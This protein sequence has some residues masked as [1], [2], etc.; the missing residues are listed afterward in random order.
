MLTDSH[1]HLFDY[2]EA[3]GKL[4]PAGKPDTAGEG[5]LAVA[6]ATPALWCLSAHEPAEFAMQENAASA[7]PGRAWLS[8]GIHPQ[9]PEMTHF[10][11]LADLARARRIQ[12]IGECGFDL[13][14]DGFRRTIDRQKTVWS[15]QLDLAIETRLPLIVHCRKA[16][17]LVFADSKRLKCVSAVV[18][19]GWPGSPVEA[20]SFLDKG[21]NAYFSAGKGLMRGDRSLI[22]TVRALPPSRILTETDAPWMRDRDQDYTSPSEI[23]AVAARAAEIAGLPEPDFI[24]TV[25]KNFR[26]VFGACPGS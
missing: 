18:F 15:R 26:T 16:L 21:V 14:N 7:F 20:R 4:P 17:H 5:I 10:D 19:H 6:N 3:A 11:F 13:F 24:A 12:A 8:F 9:E 23:S 22:E 25:E 1:L 2:L